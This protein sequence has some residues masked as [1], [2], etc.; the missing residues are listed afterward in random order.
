VPS[1]LTS[2]NFHPRINDTH[3]V[4]SSFQHLQANASIW[5]RYNIVQSAIG[6]PPPPHAQFTNA[7]NSTLL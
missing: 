4:Y 3:C 7:I 2:P 1:S 6:R 5:N